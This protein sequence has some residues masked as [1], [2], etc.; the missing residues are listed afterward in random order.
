MELLNPF[1]S[2]EALDDKLS[3][4]DI[5]ARDQLGR[6]LN[7]EMQMQLKASFE[8]RIV[9]YAAKRHQQQL[10]QAQD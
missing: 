7:V 1:N 6:Q 10:Q 3:I 5:I 4:L 2:K 8:N 9:Y